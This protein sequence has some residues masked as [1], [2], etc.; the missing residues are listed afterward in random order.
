[1]REK[2]SR[3]PY[4]GTPAGRGPPPKPTRRSPLT[5]SLRFLRILGVRSTPS[6]PSFVGACGTGISL[7]R[8]CVAYF[9]R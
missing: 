3:E 5:T 4:P 2:T 8:S 7:R 6:S 9:L 1:M